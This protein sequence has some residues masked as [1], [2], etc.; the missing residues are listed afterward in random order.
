MGCCNGQ[1]NASRSKA[2]MSF[3]RRRMGVDGVCGLLCDGRDTLRIFSKAGCGWPHGL[4]LLDDTLRRMNVVLCGFAT[5]VP[6]LLR[7]G[8][9]LFYYLCSKNIL[10][11]SSVNS[12]IRVG[13]LGDDAAE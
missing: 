5:N 1:Q 13:P 3:G 8:N 10:F 9:P 2:V 11:L 12:F 4:I 6:L 7:A